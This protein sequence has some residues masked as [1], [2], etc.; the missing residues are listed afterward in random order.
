MYVINNQ[1]WFC[2]DVLKGVGV[3]SSKVKR[4]KT[5][6]MLR[7]LPLLR[8]WVLLVVVVR[9]ACTHVLGVENTNL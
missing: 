8:Y 1:V 4:R 9:K 7:V 2:D 6:K 3:L 5:L